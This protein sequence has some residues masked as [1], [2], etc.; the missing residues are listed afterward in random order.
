MNFQDCYPQQIVKYILGF[1]FLGA[2]LGLLL[3]CLTLFPLFG[4]LMVLPVTALA[5][6]I[7]R[8]NFNDQCEIDFSA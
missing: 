2:A 7:F 3:I 1:M 5:F 4:F 6:I 8:L